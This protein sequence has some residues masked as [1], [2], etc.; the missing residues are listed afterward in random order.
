MTGSADT[1]SKQLQYLAL[2]TCD[3]KSFLEGRES[4]HHP[5]GCEVNPPD[6]LLGVTLA[7]V[8][9]VGLLLLGL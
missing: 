8:S 1:F 4:N 3:A 6:K 2:L 5:K 9:D 7:I